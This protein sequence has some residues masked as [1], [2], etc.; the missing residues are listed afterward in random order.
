VNREH[1]LAADVI[2]TLLREN[3]A[4][5]RG[6]TRPGPVLELPAAGG[7]TLPLEPDGF[8]ADLRLARLGG[9]A[10]AVTLADVDTMIAAIGDPLDVDG[11]AA[12]ATECRHA[13]AALRLHDRE[14]P[15]SGGHEEPGPPGGLRYEELGPP[16]GF[17]YEELGPLGSLRYDALAAMMPHPA[18]PTWACRLGMSDQDARRYAPEYAPEFELCWAAVPRAAVISAGHPRPTWWPSM[19][20]V[21]LP[22]TLST[23]HE[24]MPVHPL[25]ARPAFAGT[26]PDEAGPGGLRAAGA[27]P[28]PQRWLRVRPTLSTRTVVVSEHPEHH[29]K[30]PLPVS[31]LGLR[32]HRA[33]KPAALVDG[34][35]MYRLLADIVA[36][37]YELDGLLLTDDRD[38]AHA[39]QPY[40]GY[41][42]RRL[43]AGLDRCRI[44]PVA[45]LVALDDL[46]ASFRGYLDLVFGV[47]VCLFVRYGI[48]L[49]SHQQ[50]AAVVSG[51]GGT[52]LLVKDFDGALVNPARLGR[53]APPFAD[54]RLL[55]SS[56]DALAD[57]FITITVHLC[58]GAI[59]FGLARRGYAPLRDLLATV[60]AALAAALARYDGDPAAA[61]LRARVFD[62]DR[63]PGKAMVTAGTLVDKARTGASDINKFYG[64]TGPNYLKDGR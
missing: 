58:A 8:L 46:A 1:E 51:P 55:T 33:I 42:L 49:E 24:L 23:S 14:R 12:F 63:L 30:L 61:L 26:W 13:L 17:R 50:N 38:Y 9:A 40:L 45:A 18:Y 56:D 10:P 41:L 5:L 64:T 52:R 47:A 29:L 32:N 59:A 54:R 19:T 22:R 31:T 15:S 21:G 39:G 34:A 36:G 2:D 7:R 44:V 53:P 4:G 35:L 6:W 28:A 3:Y 20:D 25:T 16:G 37:D 27:V 62:A 11:A 43:P 57:V 48:A 60:R